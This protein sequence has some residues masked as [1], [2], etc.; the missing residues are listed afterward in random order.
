MSLPKEND[1]HA[2]SARRMQTFRN[3][4]HSNEDWYRRPAGNLPRRHILGGLKGNI[5]QIVEAPLATDEGNIEISNVEYVASY[6]WIPSEHPTIIVPGT[7]LRD[8]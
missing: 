5:I 3:R 8:V 6:N 7:I 1:K 4:Q 2:P